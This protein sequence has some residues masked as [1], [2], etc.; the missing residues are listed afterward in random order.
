MWIDRKTYDDMRLDNA[1]AQTEAR[2]LS[3]QNRAL[4]VTID[5]FRVRISQLEMERAQMLYNY[6]GVKITTPTIERA[7]E[8]DVAKALQ[9]VQGFQDIGDQEAARLGIGWND[10]GTLRVA[11]ER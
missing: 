9:A 6:T 4:Q 8:S 7:P 3:E 2:V 11:T 10:D 1:K 5:W